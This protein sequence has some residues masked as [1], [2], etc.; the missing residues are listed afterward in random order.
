MPA[1]RDQSPTGGSY[2]SAG[3]SASP[4]ASPASLAHSHEDDPRYTGNEPMEWQ[5][6][7]A[8]RTSPQG[9]QQPYLFPPPPV[10]FTY[11][12]GVG[13]LPHHPPPPRVLEPDRMSAYSSS[14]GSTSSFGRRSI[15][16]NAPNLRKRTLAE[17]A[18]SAE[19]LS[20]VTS[21]ESGSNQLPP[22]M[23]ATNPSPPGRLSSISSLLNHDDPRD[24][25]RLDPSGRQQQQGWSGS[26]PQP[27]PG[28]AELDGS[29]SDRRA[30]LQR[31]TE[32]M[33]EALKAKERE[34]AEL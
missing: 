18:S 14:P 4:D 21:L 33:R 7:S 8:G 1:L 27:L 30:R 15:S 6:M 12:S 34:L 28:M 26:H 11:G 5:P 9:M 13:S 2:S 22:I 3:S 29:K 20:M 17:T 32:H 23:S 16:P 31:E 25:F 19:A 24:E 10:D